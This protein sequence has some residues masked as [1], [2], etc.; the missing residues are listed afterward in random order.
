MCWIRDRDCSRL[1]AR[2]SRFL[3]NS[4]VSVKVPDI[5]ISLYCTRY[6]AYFFESTRYRSIPDIGVYTRNLV[7]PDIPISGKPRHQVRYDQ[8]HIR[9]SGL[10]ISATRGCQLRY[11]DIR[12]HVLYSSATLRYY[13]IIA[14]LLY[15]S[16]EFYGLWYHSPYHIHDII[17]KILT[18]KSLSNPMIS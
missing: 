8:D 12:Y 13:D 14:C 5:R 1:A 11:R 10:P 18:M 9:M 6:R 15:H 17:D 3:A 16:M 7:N 2:P 4:D